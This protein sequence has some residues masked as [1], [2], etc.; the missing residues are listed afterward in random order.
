MVS[1]EANILKGSGPAATG[2]SEPS[3][4]EIAGDNSFAGKGRAE[5][6]NVSQV[7]CRLPETA[8]DYKQEREVSPILGEPQLTKVL[9]VNAVPYALI[10]RRRRP[11]QDV[12]QA[13][14]QMMTRL[15]PYKVGPW[16][17]TTI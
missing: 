4:F 2:V 10:E 12:A 1:C 8:M 9:R 14:P 6:A 7:V 16:E 17:P 3:V 5:V 11:R 13:T 15:E